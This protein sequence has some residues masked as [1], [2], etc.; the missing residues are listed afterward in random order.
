LLRFGWVKWRFGEGA[1]HGLSKV[2]GVDVLKKPVETEL[3]DEGT[4]F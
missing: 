3:A 4:A 1:A 2:P